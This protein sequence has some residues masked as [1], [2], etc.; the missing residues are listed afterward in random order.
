MNFSPGDSLMHRLPAGFK[1]LLVFLVS[2]FMVSR[3]SGLAI[4][5]TLA[6]FAVISIA[7]TP[8]STLVRCWRVGVLIVA[9]MTLVLVAT[10]LISGAQQFST[11]QEI[12]VMQALSDALAPAL[13]AGAQ[14]GAALLLPV[15]AAL[16]LSATTSSTAIMETLAHGIRPLF[17]DRAARRLSLAVLLTFRTVP[18]AFDK[19]R[20]V[21]DAFR[22]RGT[23]PRPWNIFVPFL[24][25]LVEHAL[26]TSVALDARRVLH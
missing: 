14:S 6:A 10:R 12:S 5:L 2:V 8:I 3:P 15:E 16:L 17:G 26:A 20:E 1:L 19:Y 9:P 7:L 13:L 4:L 23:K 18:L 25:G 24:I 21:Q 11:T 22:A